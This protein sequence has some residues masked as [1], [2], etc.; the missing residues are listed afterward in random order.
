MPPALRE[1][2]PNK[3]FFLVRFFLHL[4]WIQE[5]TDQKKLPIWTFLKRCYILVLGVFQI[6][7]ISWISFN[8]Y[9]TENNV[10]FQAT[11][12]VMEMLKVSLF[13]HI[14]ST[15][16]LLHSGFMGEG[17]PSY[18]ILWQNSNTQSQDG[19][20]KEPNSVFP[21]ENSMC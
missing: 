11:S 8:E 6:Y 3:E 5:N 10:L 15:N 20:M 16:Q 17:C 13:F 12:Y 7:R 21:C 9:P 2:C 19:L 1:K 14:V 4:N 18:D